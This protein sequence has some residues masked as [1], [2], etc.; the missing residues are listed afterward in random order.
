M[1]GTCRQDG[2]SDSPSRLSARSLIYKDVWYAFSFNEILIPHH[3]SLQVRT[4]D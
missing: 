2:F 1:Q 3:D 4:A